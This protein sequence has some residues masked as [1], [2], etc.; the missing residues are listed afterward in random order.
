MAVAFHELIPVYLKERKRLKQFVH[1][2]CSKEKKQLAEMNIIFCND[3][4]L[5]NINRQH[6]NHDFYTDIITFD[7]SEKINGPITAELYISIE[8]V[9][10]NAAALKVSL[11]KELH[12]VIFHGVLHLCGFGDKTKKDLIVMR[13][14]EEEYLDLYLD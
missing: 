10:D 4:Y 8:R 6:L 1:F 11:L 7:I 5:L 13:S 9:K 3:E 12:R 14:K 2:L